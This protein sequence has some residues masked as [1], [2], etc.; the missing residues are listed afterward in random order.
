MELIELAKEYGL[1]TIKCKYCKK[2]VVATA[3]CQKVCKSV[4][5]QKKRIAEKQ[6]TYLQKMKKIDDAI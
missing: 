3:P 4:S 1:R 6:K 2:E 5:C